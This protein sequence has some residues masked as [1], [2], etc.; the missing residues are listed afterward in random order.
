MTA[1]GRHS[2][3]GPRKSSN[4]TLIFGG[5]ILL[6]FVGLIFLAFRIISIPSSSK[7]SQKAHDLSS[8]AH[9]TV[10]RQ[11][12]DDDGKK[13]QWVEV[14]SLEPRAYVYHNF[15]DTVDRPGPRHWSQWTRV[16]YREI[17]FLFLAADGLDTKR[18]CWALSPTPN[19]EEN[20]SL[21][22]VCGSHA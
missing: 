10:Q 21:G 8:T 5:F 22:L 3:V 20:E 16:K 19:V 2:R 12:D 11:D 1:K 9:N 4:S 13:D 14:I 17:C 6:S 18:S 7:G 15:L